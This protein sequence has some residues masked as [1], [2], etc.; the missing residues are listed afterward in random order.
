VLLERVEPS[1]RRLQ[2]AL[3]EDEPV[4]PRKKRN[5]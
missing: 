5:R 1:E 3:V 2:F 4:R